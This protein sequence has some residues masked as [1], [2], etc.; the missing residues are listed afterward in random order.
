MPIRAYT[1][2]GGSA[3]ESEVSKYVKFGSPFAKSANRFSPSM[4][5]LSLRAGTRENSIRQTP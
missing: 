1:F 2:L 4:Q 3:H 5:K